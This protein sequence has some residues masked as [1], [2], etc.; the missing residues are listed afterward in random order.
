MGRARREVR[1]SDAEAR[2]IDRSWRISYR[3][4]GRGRV[5][6]SLGLGLDQGP[7]WAVIAWFAG[8]ALVVLA[9]G[10]A[11]SQV[12]DRLADRAGLG[13]AVMGALFLG[14][15]TSLSGAVVSVV[16][17]AQALP[18]LAVSNAL[19]G[20]PVQTAFLAVADLAHRRANLEHAAASPE[21][22]M[23]GTLLVL[24]LGIALI[25]VATPDAAILGLHPASFAIPIVYA[26]GLRLLREARAQPMWSPR[27]TPETQPDE[28]AE[29]VSRGANG[30]LWASFAA[31][32]VIVAAAGWVIAESGSAIA[33]RTGL[34]ET[35]VGTFLT[36]ISTSTPEL[37]TTVAAVR[38]GALTLAV[39]GI[40]GGNAY[41]VLLLTYSD[42]AYREGSIFAA[43]GPETLFL[44]AASQV[45]TAILLLGFLRREKHGLAN[46]GSESVAILLVY[47]GVVTWLLR[48]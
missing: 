43:I 2:H 16:S 25:A 4:R 28:P 22:L 9:A 13:E 29:A 32:A 36:A 21:S 46:I 23:Q 17:A 37:V 48:S 8:G 41:D 39:S 10:V 38:R 45:M 1:G 27:V 6:V 26:F 24:V 15:T 5:A 34:S 40:L 12:A 19:G 44:I 18:T 14:A 11:L 35:I 20:I 47:A 30:A 31:L 7:F 42:I 3:R 33:A